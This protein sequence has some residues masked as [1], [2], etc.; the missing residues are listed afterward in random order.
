MYK[1]RI[2]TIMMGPNIRYMPGDVI[3][4]EDSIGIQLINS[5]YAELITESQMIQ[6]PEN[7]MMSKAVSRKP[8]RR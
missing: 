7:A 2:K 8:G 5:R 3:D 4:V 6:P 1:V